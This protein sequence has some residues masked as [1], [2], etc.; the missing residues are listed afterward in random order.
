MARELSFAKTANADLMEIAR[1]ITH[2]YGDARVGQGFIAK[3][4]RRCDRIA[5]LPGTLGTA[6][7]ELRPDIRSV[8]EQGYVIFFRYLPGRVEI[9]RILEGHRDIAAQFDPPQSH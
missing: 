6:R 5:S 3:L 4:R 9:V 8:S 7:P 1:F 2:D